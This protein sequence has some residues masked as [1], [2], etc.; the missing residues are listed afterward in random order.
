MCGGGPWRPGEWTD[1]TQ[2]A[3]LLAASLLE[4]G[5]LVES[6]VFA[7]FVAWVAAGPKDVGIATRGVLQSGSPWHSAAADYAAS[8][9]ASAGNGSLM[10]TMPLAIRTSREPRDV[11][12]T[13]A[14]S[15][16]GLTH[17]DPAAGE[18]CAIYHAMVQV[19]LAGDDPL[20]ALP[21]VLLLVED[22]ERWSRVL[23][24]Q[25]T[26]ADATESNGAVWPTLGIAV[27][28]LRQGWSY[29][30]A[31][32]RVIDLGGDTDTVACVTGG[33]LGAVQ[34]IQSIPARWTSAVHGELPGHA[35]V[36]AGLRELQLLAARLDG[37]SVAS[38]P[39][40]DES[41]G[42]S[43]VEVVPRVW[44][45]DLPGAAAS[46]PDLFVISLCRTFGRIPHKNWRQVYLVDDNSNLDVDAAL[47]DVLDDIAALRAEGRDVLVHCYAGASR[48]GLVLRG[49]LRRY[50][51]L[52]AE[53]ATAEARRRWRQ[54]ALWNRSFDAALERLP[55]L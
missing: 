31:L 33:L 29:A 53:E 9:H 23:D 48:T 27:W 55:V 32:R 38:D 22:P 54:T 34:G 20:A 15:Q 52:S 13:A 51:G 47:A 41:C 4:H 19:A 42:L 40:P 21:D 37:E 11:T 2:M 17:G 30:D 46:D 5:E 25:W 45:T 8:G 28:A 14:R 7:R 36:A 16:S 24:P 3:L 39:V 1:D 50:E 10:R 49:W 12:M 6:D 18:G 35:P 44:V 26:P 43:P